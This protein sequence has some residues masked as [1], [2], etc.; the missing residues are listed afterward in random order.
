MSNGQGHDDAGGYGAAPRQNPYAQ[1]PYPPDP[2]PQNPYGRGPA[3]QNPYARPV[4]PQAHPYPAPPGA[5]QPHH[6]AQPDPVAP[7]APTP[8]APSPPPVPAGAEAF[9]GPGPRRGRIAVL[10]QFTLQWIYAPLWIAALVAL[11]ALLLWSGSSGPS[12]PDSDGWLKVNRAFIPPRRLKAELTGRPEDWERY[13]APILARRIAA[14]EA[15][16]AAGGGTPLPDL[17][18][19]VHTEFAVRLYRGLGAAGLVRL[20]ERHGWHGVPVHSDPG[21]VRLTRRFPAPTGVRAPAPHDPP[22]APGT[23]WGPQPTRFAP[24]LPVMFL[25]QFVYVPV[26]GVLSLLAF[27]VKH[28]EPD[29]WDRWGARWAVGPRAFWPEFTNGRAAWDR[30]IRRVLDRAVQRELAQP[31]ES[32]RGVTAPDGTFLRRIRVNRA[33]YRGAGAHHV[34]R[35]AAEQGWTLDPTYLPDPTNSVRLSRPDHTRP[36]P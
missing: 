19:A 16:H 28:P 12:G 4:P 36:T 22:A 25:L 21:H 24:L 5:A 7:Q 32:Y 11:F 2:Y 9:P 34:L 13:V 23:P 18:R 29:H 17:G 15:E 8:Q 31:A 20:A 1:G 10:L 27:W 30:H 33:T 14:A 26:L 3:P 6:S 35:L